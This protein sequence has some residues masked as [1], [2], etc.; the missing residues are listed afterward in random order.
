MKILNVN[1]KISPRVRKFGK[2]AIILLLATYLFKSYVFITGSW[3]YK[4]TVE[5]ETPEGIKTGYAVREVSAEKLPEFTPASATGHAR[6][7]KGEAVVVDLGERG[8]LFALLKGYKIGADYA[9][10]IVYHAL[11]CAE[12]GGS[13]GETTANNIRYYRSLKSAKAVLTPDLYPM[14]VRFRDAKDPK[15]VENLLEYKSCADAKTRIRDSSVC[16]EKD[17][18]DEAFGQGVKVKSVTI[19]MTEEPV[20]RGIAGKYMPIYFP[21]DEYLKWYRSLPY[22][23]PRQIHAHDFGAV[24]QQGE[25]K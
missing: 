22:G 6:L 4:M 3:R 13:L 5:V 9:W 18:F 8:T 11:P 23:D 1:K 7:E 19:E 20:T 17:H 14:M 24:R 16:L 12:C 10:A 25:A 21:Q 2:V 15:T